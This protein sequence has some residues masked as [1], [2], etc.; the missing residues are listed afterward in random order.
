MYKEIFVPWSDRAES[1]KND[2]WDRNNKKSGNQEQIKPYYEAN[3]RLIVETTLPVW[4]NRGRFAFA[5]CS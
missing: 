1:G 2:P 5:F 4:L 3:D